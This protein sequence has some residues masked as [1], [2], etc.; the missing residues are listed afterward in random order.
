MTELDEKKFKEYLQLSGK[1][2]KAILDLYQNSLYETGWTDKEIGIFEDNLN[3]YTE[4]VNYI[5]EHLP[6]V[7]WDTDESK[8]EFTKC[9][10]EVIAADEKVFRLVKIR[11]DAYKT[12]RAF[13][14]VL[15]SRL[16]HV[17]GWATSNDDEKIFEW[18][19]EN[20][21]K[22]PLTNNKDDNGNITYKNAPYLSQW[23]SPQ[24]GQLTYDLNK[25]FRIKP[26][27]DQEDIREIFK[28]YVKARQGVFDIFNMLT[29]TSEINGYDKWHNYLDGFITNDTRVVNDKNLKTMYSNTKMD[30]DFVTVDDYQ[31]IMDDKTWNARGIY[32]SW[33]DEEI[34]Q[35]NQA[36]RDRRRKEHNIQKINMVGTNANACRVTT[37][38]E[39]VYAS[40]KFYPGDII[41]IVPTRIIDKSS[42]FSKDVREIAFEVVPNEEWVIPFGYCQYY[43]LS[44][45]S[46]APNCDFIW[47]PIKRVIVIKAINKIQK[48][49]KLI[50]NNV[51]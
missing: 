45:E 12:Y 32:E 8:Y 15:I 37:D 41:E 9:F 14:S 1:S 49:E 34:L 51:N 33:F 38:G 24:L 29:S 31:Q 23:L 11:H 17:M 28:S 13:R 21:A 18:F 19:N 50:L 26:S 40:T 39:H 20:C 4:A 36:I 7:E 25:Q 46:V 22:V 16:N 6:E 48:H 3:R 42:L 27:Y 30:T 43:D 10:N 47:D 2:R 35:Y 5:R 44:N